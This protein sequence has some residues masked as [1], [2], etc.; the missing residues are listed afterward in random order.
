MGHDIEKSWNRQNVKTVSLSLFFWQPFLLWPQ[1]A[2]FEELA[3][4]IYMSSYENC[5]FGTS[6]W[7]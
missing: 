4:L 5:V 1:T 2:A 3:S 7:T 6:W